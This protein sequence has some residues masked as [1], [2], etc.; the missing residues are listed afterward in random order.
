MR[1]HLLASFETE[2]ISQLILR[3]K[4][5]S[6]F[7][8]KRNISRVMIIF[9][10]LTMMGPNFSSF[11]VISARQVG[12][13]SNQIEAAINNQ[14][15]LPLVLKSSSADSYGNDWPMVAANPQRTSWTLEEVSGDLYLDWYHPI[16]PYIPYKIQP[17]AA[18]GKI[19]VST[20]TRIVCLS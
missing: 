4:T 6:S 2:R 15:F 18:N 17:I 13:S 16:E 19:Y 5:I 3:F 7:G 14:I 11:H 20:A 10:I 12:I 1:K 8:I 9:V